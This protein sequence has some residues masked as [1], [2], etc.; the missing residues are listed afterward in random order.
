M[1]AIPDTH[2]AA[3]AAALIE[4]I[5]STNYFNGRIE[6]DH[7]DAHAQLVTTLIIYRDSAG[8]IT[9]IVPVWWQYLHLL[10]S[11]EA[12]TDFDWAILREYLLQ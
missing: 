3:L 11:N 2:Y 8:R 5:G 9:D 6:V 1:I 10:P 4:A 7:Q 12:D